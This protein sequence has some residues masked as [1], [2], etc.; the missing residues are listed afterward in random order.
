MMQ[1]TESHAMSNNHD[2]K[3]IQFELEAIANR[4]SRMAKSLD[5]MFEATRDQGDHIAGLLLALSNE[6]FQAHDE[7]N[8][9]AGKLAN[10]DDDEDQSIPALLERREQLKRDL[11]DVLIDIGATPEPA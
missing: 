2:S 6:A 1:L 9:L 11:A 10:D 5:W 3:K 4:L 8:A 7:L